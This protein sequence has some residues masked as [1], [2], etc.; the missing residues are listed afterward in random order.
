MMNKRN[1]VTAKIVTYVFDHFFNLYY[2]SVCLD[3]DLFV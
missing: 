1:R 3:A 2:V